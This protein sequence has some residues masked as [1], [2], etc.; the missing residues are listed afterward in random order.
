MSGLRST[1][2]SADGQSERRSAVRRARGER[3]IWQRRYREHLIRDEADFNA[4]MDY[5]HFNPVKHVHVTKVADWPFPT[6]HRLVEIGIY[7]P[8]W[9][10]SRAADA[11]G[12]R[13]DIR[14][15]AV[16]LLRLT[17]AKMRGLLTRGFIGGLRLGNARLICIAEGLDDDAEQVVFK[18]PGDLTGLSV[19]DA[20]EAEIQVGLIHGRTPRVQSDRYTWSWSPTSTRMMSLSRIRISNTMR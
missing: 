15:N 3:G 14:L 2:I 17:R 16:R 19:R 18:K 4:H 7:S 1:V 11:I 6:F 5:L 12:E 9:A 10:G 13:V 8:D 20:V